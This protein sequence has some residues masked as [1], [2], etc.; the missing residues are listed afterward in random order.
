M[1]SKTCI[2]FKLTIQ[3]DNF[4]DFHGPEKSRAYFS[5]YIGSFSYWERNKKSK[6]CVFCTFPISFP[7]IMPL[8]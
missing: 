6:M 2:Y 8:K 3:S 7:F 4:S 5:F 1:C